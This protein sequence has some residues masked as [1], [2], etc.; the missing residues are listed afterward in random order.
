MAQYCNGVSEL[1]GS[2]ARRMWSKVWPGRPENEV[3]I[4]HITNGV[5]IPSW[6]S[7]ENSLLFER[8]LGPD[9]YLNTENE[10]TSQRIDEIYDEELWR[11]HEMSRSRLVRTCRKLMVKQYG[12]QNAPKSMIKQAESALDPK[13]LTIGFARRFATYK[14]AN[15]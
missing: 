11:A 9:W 4:T 3:P 5:H 14:R 6:I 15:L 10:E 8:Y 7:I 2:V 1:H 13:I 12:R